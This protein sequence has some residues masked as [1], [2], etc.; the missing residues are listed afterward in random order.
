MLLAWESGSSMTAQVYDTSVAKPVGGT[1]TIDAKDHA[2]QAFK[3]Y[4]DGSVAHP[5]AGT[6][7]TSIRVARVTPLH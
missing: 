3:A 7:A 4:A 5:A 1:F 2:Y 6:G